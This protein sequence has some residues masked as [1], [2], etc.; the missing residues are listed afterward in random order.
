M[1]QIVQRQCLKDLFY[2]H[3]IAVFNACVPEMSSDE[4]L[5]R[6]NLGITARTLRRAR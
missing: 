2:S 5:C 6:L 3:D 1:L 4:L